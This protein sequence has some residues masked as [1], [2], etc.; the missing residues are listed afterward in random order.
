MAKSV[1]LMI[2]RELNETQREMW[3]LFVEKF[4]GQEA[5]RLEH[6]HSEGDD[7]RWTYTSRGF[8]RIASDD[9]SEAILLWCEICPHDFDV[10]ASAD[11]SDACC[12]DCEL[13]MGEDVLDAIVDEASAFRHNR[14]IDAQMAA[15]WRFGME[16][17]RGEKT[18]PR[19]RDWHHLSEMHRERLEMDPAEAMEFLAHH[20]HLFAGR[21]AA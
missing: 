2:D 1:R 21:I 8:H 11:H 4:V 13:E 9:V 16:F 12:E 14:W 10:D 18:D 5:D 3:F 6:S 7:G 17:S 15:G 20:R 19:M